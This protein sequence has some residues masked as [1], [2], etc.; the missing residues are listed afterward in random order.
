M[1][2]LKNFLTFCH[3]P[4]NDKEF[5]KTQTDPDPRLG[6]FLRIRKRIRIRKDP[7]FFTDPDP[8]PLGQNS[9]DPDP[10][11]RNPGFC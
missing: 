9:T 4:K 2:G 7:S 10:D 8:D 1:A 5:F 11:P 6:K 3:F